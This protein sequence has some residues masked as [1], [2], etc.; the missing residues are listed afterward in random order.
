MKKFDDLWLDVRNFCA[1]AQELDGWN[2]A[3]RAPYLTE[4]KNKQ[5]YEFYQNA[6]GYLLG[7]GVIGD[8]HEYGVFSAR[9]FRM[10][11]SEACKYGFTEMEFYAFD[12]FEGLPKSTSNPKLSSWTS[13]A[14]A[15]SQD[16]FMAL[17]QEQG[18]FLNKVNLI[19]GFFSDSMR[20]I[21]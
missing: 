5:T 17:I 9:T 7:S 3:K 1:D 16:E 13:G 8:Y 15:M 10:A 20:L 11:L 2:T 12:S 19:K 18:I 6:F 21:A 14:M 4:Q